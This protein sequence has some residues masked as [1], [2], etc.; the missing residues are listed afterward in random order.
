[1]AVDDEGR[2]HPIDVDGLPG[3]F[4]VQSRGA[5]EDDGEPVA[6]EDLLP[7]ARSVFDVWVDGAELPWAAHMWSV[8]ATAGLTN[9]RTN[10]EHARAVCRLLALSR[11]Y[12]QFCVR[13]FEIGSPGEW[14]FD[15]DD[16]LGEYP[17]LDPFFLGQLVERD[18]VDA[19][20]ELDAAYWEGSGSRTPCA[21]SCDRSTRRSSAR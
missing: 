10:V 1:M 9:A 16:V 11:L 12:R 7:I 6:W 14:A 17:R 5:P 15:V 19:D 2:G 18:G 21:S 4:M 8:L 20:L 13:A 3:E